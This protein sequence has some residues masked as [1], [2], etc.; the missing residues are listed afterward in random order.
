[1]V[2]WGSPVPMATPAEEPYPSPPPAFQPHAYNV[3]PAP[4]ASPV[5]ASPAPADAPTAP[6]SP[7]LWPLIALNV[8]F[9]LLTYLLGPL[10]TW[11]R[12]PGRSALG[13]LG[14]GLILTAGVWAAGRM[15][16]LRL[17]ASGPHRRPVETRA[18]VVTTQP[19]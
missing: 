10:G 2:A 3:D 7:L 14:I 18:V 8:V 13:W 17:A 15:V 16:R 6:I 4:I 19:G 9:N 1:M 5:Y 11:L 12:G